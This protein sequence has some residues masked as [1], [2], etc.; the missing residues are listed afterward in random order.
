V[1]LIDLLKRIQS[2]NTPAIINGIKG[3]VVEVGEELLT[4]ETIRKKE[5]WEGKKKDISLVRET[6]YVPIGQIRSIS[7]GEKEIPKSQKEL[8][9]EKELDRW[10]KEL[11][12]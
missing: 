7:E 2:E 9:M 4:L 3:R 5:K 8:E 11:G 6:I 12:I 1:K 10:E